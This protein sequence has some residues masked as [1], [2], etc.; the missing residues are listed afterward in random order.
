[1]N[2]C[3]AAIDENRGLADN[4]GIPW[5]LPT[6]KQFFRDQVAEG[7]ILLGKGTYLE[8][9]EPM[10]GRTN[11]VATRSSK[12]L[13]PG[14]FAVHDVAKF[15]QEHEGERINN[16][17]GAGLFAETMQF[18]DELILT[19]IQADFHC[20]KFFPPYEADFVR[21]SQSDPITENG[22]TY[23]FTVWKRKK[24]RH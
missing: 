10:Y 12:P 13:K 18:A 11:Y 16:I 24:P 9:D 14:F 2:R 17:G 7:I 19:L 4:K 1:M 20:T 5:D 15:F 6:D 23:C 8:F 21:V 3:I 22:I